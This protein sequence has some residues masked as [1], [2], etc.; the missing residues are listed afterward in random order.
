MIRLL[1]N[2][3]DPRYV[4]DS[5]IVWG[6]SLVVTGKLELYG[7]SPTTTQTRL[8]AVAAQGDTTLKVG[9]TAGWA[10]GQTIGISPSFSKFYEYEKR[11]ITAL[12]ATTVTFATGLRFMHYGAVQPI[13]KTQGDIDL[14]CV[15]GLLDRNIKIGTD[16]NL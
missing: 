9:S 1:G 2:V 8:T 3:T 7:K 16:S 12:T 13:T 14:R 4:V 6:K 11:T 15:V 10:V 5:R